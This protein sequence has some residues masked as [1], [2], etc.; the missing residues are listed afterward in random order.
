MLRDALVRS[1]APALCRIWRALASAY[2]GQL[3]EAQSDLEALLADETERG[4]EVLYGTHGFLCEVLR[5]QGDLTRAIPHGRRAVELAEASGSSFSRVE[6]A[7]F[8]GAASLAAGDVDTATSALEPALRLARAR[9]N[10]LWYEPRILATL[11]EARM[12][13]G[14]RPGARALLAEARELV[15]Q[16]RGWRLSACDVVLAWVRLLGS[17]AALDRAVVESAL[18][19]LEALAAG[20][21]AQVYRRMADIERARLG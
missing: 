18:A 10:A 13:A 17:E 21:G 3:A 11:A 16:G 5:L 9:R 14:D 2:L 15:E 1:T 20:F 4:L 19:S 12:A 7:A 6:A 8:L